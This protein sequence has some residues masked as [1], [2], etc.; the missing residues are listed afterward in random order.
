V[1]EKR[2]KCPFAAREK[3]KYA[4]YLQHLKHDQFY[5]VLLH[6]G[7]AISDQLVNIHVHQLKAERES[8]GRFVAAETQQFKKLKEMCNGPTHG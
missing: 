5:P 6:V 2:V 7:L 3:K 4:P 8:P 1:T